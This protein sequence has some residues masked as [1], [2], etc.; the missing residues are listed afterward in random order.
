MVYCH[1]GSILKEE[2]LFMY[3]DVQWLK[4][5]ALGMKAR[6]EGAY[7]ITTFWLPGHLI[8]GEQINGITGPETVFEVKRLMPMSE[9]QVVSVQQKLSEAA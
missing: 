6:R 9:F 8:L 1:F 3:H 7:Q 2:E 5:H 4:D